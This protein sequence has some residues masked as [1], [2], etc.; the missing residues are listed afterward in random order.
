MKWIVFLLICGSL[1][2]CGR[3]NKE[4]H[5][6]VLQETSSSPLTLFSL[7]N[8]NGIRMTVTNYG[9]RIVSLWVPDKNGDLGD[10]VLGYDSLEEYLSDDAYFGALI[11][12]YANRVAKGKF[13]LEGKEFQLPVNNGVNTL[14]GGPKGFHKVFWDVVPI[15]TETGSRLELN[16][17]SKDGEAGFPGNL[18]VKVIYYLTDQNELMIEYEATTDQTTIVNLTDHSYFNLLGEGTGDILNHQLMINAEKYCPVDETSIPTGELQLVAGTPFDFLKPHSIGEFIEYADPQLKIGKGY[19]HNWV[20]KKDSNEFS[21][22]ARVS[23]SISGRVME[24]WTTDIGVQFY[25]GNFLDG[26]GKGKG[27]KPYNF[28]SAICMETQHFPDTPNKKH[29]PQ[30]VLRPGEIYKK[31]TMYR[32]LVNK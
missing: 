22:A 20:L 31:K 12:R 26:S 24:L 23:E 8:K 29:F 25:S 13:L 2:G 19:D 15:R 9:G 11:G 14:H 1:I 4:I 6:P 7:Q 32:F 18:S 17:L 5:I 30:A 27:G 28:R 3:A 16:Y 10:I 21:L